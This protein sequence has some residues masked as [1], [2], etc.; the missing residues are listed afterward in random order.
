MKWLVTT[1]FVVGIICITISLVKD[2]EGKSTQVHR[3]SPIKPAPTPSGNI[4]EAP[5]AG[6]ITEETDSDFKPVRPDLI[7]AEEAT[8]L[9]TAEQEQEELPHFVPYSEEMVYAGLPHEEDLFDIEETDFTY[10]ETTL[11]LPS[12]EIHS[13]HSGYPE[14]EEVKQGTHHSIKHRKKKQ[15][16]KRRHHHTTHRSHSDKP[17]QRHK[18]HLDKKTHKPHK[19]HRL[20]KHH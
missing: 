18:H 9:P 3:T 4:P 19:L 11:G 17:T 12:E 8:I 13:E 20:R 14:D 15:K 1:L 16:K 10:P 6:N 2:C 5:M 7:P